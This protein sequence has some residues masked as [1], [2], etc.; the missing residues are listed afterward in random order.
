MNGDI[1]LEIG[2]G[3]GVGNYAVRV[4]RAAAGG[5]PTGAGARRRRGAPRRDVL[6]ATVLASAVTR[7]SDGREQPVREVG[8]AAFQGVVQWTGVGTYRASL[9]VAQQRGKKLRLVLRL[10][11]PKL[12]ALPWEMLFDPETDLLCRKEPLV[13][14]VHAP[15]TAD[16][17]EVRPPLR[18]LGLI[19]SPRGLQPL[20]VDAEKDHLA[21]ALAEPVAEGL[22]EV[23]WVPEA[24]W[25][26]VHGGLLA[27]QWHVLHFVGHGDYDTRTE[28]GV[29]AL[30]GADGRADMIEASRLADLLGEAQPTPRLVVLNSCSS[31]QAGANDLFSGTAAALARS[32]ISAVA[33]MQF[34]ISDTAAIAFARGFYTAIAHGRMWTRPRAAGGSPSSG[35]PA[36][37]SG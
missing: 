2:T 11:A 34:A 30:V 22:I 13:R 33:A 15:Y 8:S 14:H 29:L 12:A 23:I 4:I 19:A 24:T 9:G 16:P 21:E 35:P 10:T 26:G 7:R 6:E 18:V 5:E 32:G 1:E 36:A 31:G 20:D 25:R 3:S 37:W 28:E 17:L 27:G